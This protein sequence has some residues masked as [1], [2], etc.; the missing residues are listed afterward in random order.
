M[1]KLTLNDI[2]V[3]DKKVLMRV[4]FNVPLDKEQQVTDDTRIVKALPSIKHILSQG[5]KLILMSHLGRPEGKI[6]E[7][8]RLKPAGEVLSKLLKQEVKILKDCVGEEVEKAVNALNSGEVILLENLRFYK[9][10]TDNDPEFAKKLAKLGDI[11]VNDAFG[12]AHRAHASTEG[13]AKSFKIKVAGFL[14][15]KEIEYL[16][17]ALESPKRPFVAILGG[18]KVSD[19]IKV[20]TNLLAKVDTIIIGGGMAYTF[21]KAQGIPVGGS[22]LESD[23]IELAKDILNKAKDK[24]VQILL[25]KDHVVAA[26]LSADVETKIVPFDGITPDMKGLDI[27][28][29]SVE[30]FS[31][32]IK[33]AKTVLWNG[34][35]GVFEIALF[36]KGTFALAKAL[37]ESETLSIVGGGD[38]VSAVNKS[39]LSDKITHISTGGG[40]SL[41]L[42]EGKELPGLAIL[43]DK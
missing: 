36:A 38:S 26:E 28:P 19:K 7:K 24:G 18:A 12:A 5:G 21:L 31:Q 1:S 15:E 9:E 11:Y 35:M 20:I 40:A 14:M 17:G 16:V 41:E 2:E 39:G 33:E 32:I 22:L 3:K 34:P 43:T 30:L 25:P 23:Y 42:L 8:M 13:A 10:E 4:D 29:E 37:A 6:V 27:G